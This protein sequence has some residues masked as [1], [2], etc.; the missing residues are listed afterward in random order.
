MLANVLVSAFVIGFCAIALLGHWLVLTA[1]WPHP[2]PDAG[3][4]KEI[5]DPEVAGQS[6]VPPPRLAA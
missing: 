6:K 5:L 2:A 3:A 4:R 1:I